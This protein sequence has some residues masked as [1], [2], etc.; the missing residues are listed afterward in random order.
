[1]FKVRFTSS[2]ITSLC[3]KTAIG[4]TEAFLNVLPPLLAWQHRIPFHRQPF[5]TW[6]RIRC[7][8][9]RAYS[10]FWRSQRYFLPERL[11]WHKRKDMLQQSGIYLQL[12]VCLKT[13]ASPKHHGWGKEVTNHLR[14]GKRKMRISIANYVLGGPTPKK[15]WCYP[16]MREEKDYGFYVPNY[17][18]HSH[19]TSGQLTSR[20]CMNTINFEGQLLK[21]LQVILVFQ[22]Q[23]EEK[24]GSEL[25]SDITRVF[26]KYFHTS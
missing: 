1:M 4:K 2:A 22:A 20:T 23:L 11:G 8:I 21:S 13:L 24:F 7:A 10:F 26:S 3:W 15:S 12:F 14:G 17:R 19:I 9:A 18:S 16:R 6:S 5:Q 25:S